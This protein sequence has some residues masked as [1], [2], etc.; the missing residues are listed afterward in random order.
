MSTRLEVRTVAKTAAYTVKYPFDQP[1]TV[2][3]NRGASGSVTFTLPTAGLNNKG[4]YYDFRIQAAQTLVV[5][6]AAA[7]SLVTI[8]DAAADNVSFATASAKVG[9]GIRAFSDGTAWYA[10]PMGAYDGFCVDGT[11]LALRIGGTALTPTAAE[12]N[13]ALAGIL[14][15]AA[16]LNRSSDVS[17]RI[18]NLAAATLAVTETLH[19]GKTITVNKADGSTLTLPAATASGSRFRIVVGTTITSVGLIISPTGN[20]TMFGTVF[21]AQD[22]ADTVVAWEAAAGNNTI[23]LNGTT[24]GGYKGDVIELEDIATDVWRVLGHVQQTGTEATPFSTV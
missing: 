14:A 24:K 19:D 8:S 20:D 10:F 11:E 3:T 4:H 13:S 23:T 16:E 17:T 6:G 18:V 7:N 15:T 12:I 22:A 9:R 5:A 2:F 21:G 1:G